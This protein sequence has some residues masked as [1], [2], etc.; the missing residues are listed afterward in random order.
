MPC[1]WLPRHRSALPTPLARRR[2]SRRIAAVT[3]SYWRHKSCLAAAVNARKRQVR[4]DW[5]LRRW[6]EHGLCKWPWPEPV[7]ST[8][9]LRV[10]DS[11]EPLS[12]TVPAIIEGATEGWAPQ[13]W[14]PEALARR[15]GDLEWAIG[16][17]DE[18]YA[19]TMPIAEYLEYAASNGDDSPL[20]MFDE[21]ALDELTL[22][23]YEKPRCLPDDY[24]SVLGDERPPH[25]WAL[26]GGARSGVRGPGSN[27]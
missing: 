25:R 22:P 5:S 26:L 10:S 3:T 17:D 6:S 1:T 12:I 24:L 4:S 19:V 27:L 20:Y 8:E 13:R 9:C 23:P 18:G 21:H 15:H 7:V 11:C 16:A 14:S 2:C